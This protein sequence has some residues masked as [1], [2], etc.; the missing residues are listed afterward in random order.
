MSDKTTTSDMSESL[1]DSIEKDVHRFTKDT[2]KCN[3]PKP[4]KPGEIMYCQ[5][6]RQPM[7]PKD[8]SK[9]EKTRKKEFKWHMHNKCMQEMELMADVKTHGLLNER[10]HLKEELVKLQ[11]EKDA[12]KR[13]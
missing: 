9:D 11:K 12:Q 3:L 5:Y 10:K 4:P 7:L 1:A 8:F 6:C 2:S 13:R